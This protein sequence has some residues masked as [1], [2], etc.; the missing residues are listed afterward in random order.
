MPEFRYQIL[1]LGEKWE[2]E[3]RLREDV[4][5]AASELGIKRKSIEFFSEDEVGA[6]NRKSPTVAVFF[7][8]DGAS[9]ADHPA[10]TGL[11]ADSLPIIPVVSNLDGFRG[12]VPASIAGVNGLKVS[13]AAERARLVST[14]F[15][16]LHLLREERRVFIS[17]RRD[18][19]TGVAIQLFE[20]LDK[21]GFDPFL[22]TRSVRPA[23]D[24]QSELWHRMADSDIVILLDTPNFRISSWTVKEL[25]QANATNL[26]IL[27]LLWPGVGP[28]KGSAFS[29][30]FEL[31]NDSFFQKGGLNKF[32]RL[33]ESCLEEVCRR[34]ES[35]RARALAARYA[36]I[37]D[38]FCDIAAANGVRPKVQPERYLT[39][40]I[41]GKEHVVYPAIGVPTSPR[42]EDFELAVEDIVPKPTVRVIYDE[43]GILDRWHN[44]LTWLS[45]HLPIK[46]VKLSDVPYMLASGR[47]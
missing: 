1:L 13:G 6:Q 31:R 44:H 40:Q 8:Y 38:S 43:R 30:F 32:S 10:L 16:N 15:E 23:V 35:L 25:A 20:E 21:R 17:Y 14:I 41:G 22:D 37:V 18:E 36:Y 2:D 29:D 3:S 28:D 11:L 39:L 42:M 9:Q 34:A 4:L 27:H 7:G 46:T 19:S 12:K 33:S 45:S 47:L 24:F 5:Q 26:Q